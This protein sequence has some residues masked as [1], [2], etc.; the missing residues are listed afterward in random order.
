M[1]VFWYIALGLDEAVCQFGQRCIYVYSKPQIHK[2]LKFGFTGQ[3][4]P[5]KDI[6]H[7]R[8]RSQF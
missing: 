1:V 7:A 5:L 6:G 4:Q 8:F 3:V 2:I